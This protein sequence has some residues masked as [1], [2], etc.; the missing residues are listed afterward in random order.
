MK[1]T[2][3]MGTVL[4]D[5]TMRSPVYLDVRTTPGFKLYGFYEPFRRVPEEGAKQT[6]ATVTRLHTMGPSARV[7]FR[8]TSDII[9]IHAYDDGAPYV[10][11][12]YG[13]EGDKVGVENGKVYRKEY[14][15]EETFI[16]PETDIYAEGDLVVIHDTGAHGYSMGYNY[17]GK[18]RSAEVLLQADGSFKLIRRAETPAD[19]FATFDMTDFK[20]G[21]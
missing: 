1:I 17:N 15:K 10:K 19:Y 20:F 4:S 21:K 16:I 2:R 5:T 12:V 11:R 14:D 7:R 3:E 6:S 13:L 9:V 18:L 8:T